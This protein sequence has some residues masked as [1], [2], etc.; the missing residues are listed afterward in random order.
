MT[1]WKCEECGK[2]FAQNTSK[3]ILQTKTFRCP[4]CFGAH[5]IEVDDTEAIKRDLKK[6]HNSEVKEA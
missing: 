5:T 2:E 4:N 1:N 6:Y 3:Y